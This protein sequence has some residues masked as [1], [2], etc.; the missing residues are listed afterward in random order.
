MQSEALDFTCTSVEPM[1]LDSCWCLISAQLESTYPGKPTTQEGLF[2]FST[3]AAAETLIVHVGFFHVF[4]AYPQVWY[5][6]QETIY[7]P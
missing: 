3:T 5:N 7:G 4:G 6:D 2:I 1:M